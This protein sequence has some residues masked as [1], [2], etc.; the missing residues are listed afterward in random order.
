M[1]SLRDEAVICRR[2]DL[3]KRA[4]QTVFGEGRVRARMMLVGEQPGDSEDRLGHPFVGP[5]GKLLH[6][7]LAEAGIPESHVYV[8]NVVKHFKFIQRG[9]R[10]IHSK[11]KAIEIRACKP[12]LEAEIQVV[13]PALI[14]ALGATAAQSLLGS[15]FRLLANRGR[16][17]NDDPARPV[18]VTIH[19]SA[20]LRAPSDAARHSELN[21]FV[22]DLRAASAVVGV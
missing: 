22:D 18:F 17:I 7:A 11:P 4:T 1:K 13:R 16:V 21:N 3:Y 12:W 6:R 5:A 15:G 14:V 20:I 8:T 10:R 2:C 19:P 9:K